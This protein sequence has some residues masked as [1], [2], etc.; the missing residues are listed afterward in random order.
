[1][2]WAPKKPC[3]ICN[4]LNCQDPAHVRKPRQRTQATAE[5]RPDYNSWPERRR[6][7]KTVADWLAVHGRK[8]ANGDIIAR[9]PECHTMRAR[10]I[11]DHITPIAEGGSEDGPLAVH[12]GS[13][14]ARQGDRLSKARRRKPTY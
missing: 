4:R 6:R 3:R 14:S 12:C 1:M 7:Q 8:C 5:R 11:A 9:C 10:F 2:P 13:C